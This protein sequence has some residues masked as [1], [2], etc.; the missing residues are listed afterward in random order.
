MAT[1]NRIIQY[2]KPRRGQLNIIDIFNIVDTLKQR[3]FTNVTESNLDTTLL[4]GDDYDVNMEIIERERCV[5]LLEK[6]NER[7]FRISLRKL[8]YGIGNADD[9]RILGDT[10][11]ETTEVNKK[12]YSHTIELLIA[13]LSVVKLSAF[14]ASFG[15]HIDGAPMGSDYDCLVNFQNSLFHFEIKAGN[16]NNV[17]ADDLQ[18]FLFRHDYLS[19][20]ASILFLDYGNID[21]QIIRK[22]LNLKLC[23]SNNSSIERIIKIKE[24]NNRAYIL[25]PGILIVDISN[26]ND[27]LSNIK[28]SMRM[29][30]KY[31]NW[32]RSM[33]FSLLQP[34][35]IGLTGEIIQ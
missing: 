23:P 5:N 17:S 28:F 19:P 16:P 8:V 33:V 13:Y 7:N 1:L 10:T 24:N 12:K 32:H 4:V 25:S 14:S 21:E 2:G 27:T 3:G 35:Y 9:L 18:N 31:N 22:F 29:I 6:L 15:V 11:Y 30:N 26:N 20:E 34:N